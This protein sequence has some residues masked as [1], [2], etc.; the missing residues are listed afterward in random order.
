MSPPASE[1]G[2]AVLPARDQTRGPLPAEVLDTLFRHARSQNGWLP[3]PVTDAQL[4]ELFDLWKWGPTASNG[5]PA[6]VIFVR[7]AEGKS[8]LAPALSAGNLP[9]VM[10]APVVA[11]IGY[12]LAFHDHL[13]RLFPHSPEARDRMAGA[14]NAALAATTAFRNGTLQ[15]AYLML[16]ARALGLDCGPMSG[17]DATIVDRE[18]WAGTQVRT[19]FLCNLGY[20]DATKLFGRHPRLDFDD[21]CALA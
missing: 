11:I 18:F 5:L 12:D 3:N 4:R 14:H 9:K 15:G 10:S 6:R 13:P 19:N 17:F 8:R 21:C 1:G 16:A 7:T 2:S 20:G